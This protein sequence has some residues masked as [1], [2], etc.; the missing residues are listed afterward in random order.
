MSALHL[1]PEAIERG[2]NNRAAVPDHPAWFAEWSARSRRA[3]DAL[4]P[5]LDLRYGPR[6]Q[7]TLDLFL[8]AGAPRGTFVF[9]HGG[10][11]RSLDKIDHAF[12]APPLVAQGYAVALPNYDLCPHVSIATIVEECQRALIWLASEGVAHGA[13]ATPMVVGGHSAGGHLAAMMF[14]TDW[15][16]HGLS[17]APFAGGLSVSGVHDLTPLVHF[18]YNVDLKLDPDSARAVSPVALTPHTRAPLV[19]AVG[20]N[21]TSEFLRQSDIMF[22]AWP[23]NRPPGMTAPLV[24]PDTHH[25]N[26]ILEL[27][28]PGSALTQATLALL[29]DARARGAA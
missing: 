26:V 16:R 11:W 18:S 28:D 5:K 27:A 10:Y 23:D 4:R 9:I 29:A 25:F 20:A 8:P 13:A 22:D 15:T 6:P 1:N 14:A 12:V 2:Y 17:R 3:I 21:E 7:E 24:V 19:V